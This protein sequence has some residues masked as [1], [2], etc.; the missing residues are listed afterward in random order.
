[1]KIKCIKTW[2]SGYKCIDILPTISITLGDYES[3][4]YIGW[5]M[6][7]VQIRLHETS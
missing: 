7:G 4:I 2:V 3:Y 5:L 1:M 6:F